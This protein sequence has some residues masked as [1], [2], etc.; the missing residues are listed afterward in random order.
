MGSMNIAWRVYWGVKWEY[1]LPYVFIHLLLA[2]TICKVY[3]YIKSD[4]DRILKYKINPVE[5]KESWV[6]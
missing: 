1:C 6:E 2:I 4:K 5:Y 3:N